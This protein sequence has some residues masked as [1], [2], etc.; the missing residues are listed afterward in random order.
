MTAEDAYHELCAYSLSLR[1]QPFIHQLVVDCY[2]LQN[3]TASTKPMSLIFALMTLYVHLENGFT[4]KQ[5][6]RLHMQLAQQKQDW[7]KLSLPDERGVI[8]A[9]DILEC[10]P[11]DARAEAIDSWCQE[12]WAAYADSRATIIGLLRDRGF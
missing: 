10:P 4:G 2:C 6:Q 11:G 8:D 5:A 7:P 12:I 1:D 3:A 9:R